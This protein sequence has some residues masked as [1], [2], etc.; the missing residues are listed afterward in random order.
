MDSNINNSEQTVQVWTALAFSRM[1][2]PVF[3]LALSP[4]R[5]SELLQ[6]SPIPSSTRGSLPSV[7]PA[8]ILSTFRP[9]VGVIVGVLTTMFA[10]TFLLLLYAK[11]CTTNVE[12]TFRSDDGRATAPIPRIL[13]SGVDRAIIEALPLFSFAS[14]QGQKEGLECVVNL[15]RYINFEAASK[16]QACLLCWYVVSSTCPLH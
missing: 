1:V 3:S 11:H 15:C 12:V 14:L 5:A 2:S 9:S 6:L 8:S 7:G 4:A 16:V 10:I 13:D